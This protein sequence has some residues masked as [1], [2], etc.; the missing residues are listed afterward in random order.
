MTDLA[1]GSL[2]FTYD[3]PNTSSVLSM[4]L[5]E[6]WDHSSGCN[7]CF[8]KITGIGDKS[9]Y[10][11]KYL[12]FSSAIRSISSSKQLP[13]PYPLIHLAVENESAAMEVQSEEEDDLI[14]E[15]SI[16]SCEPH[17]LT[18]GDLNKRLRCE[19]IQ[20]IRNLVFRLKS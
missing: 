16:S 19:I 8:T 20:K 3:S 5:H 9:K 10:K 13:L 2:T 11:I 15:L 14:F 18:Q 17:L 7:F 4:M 6:P 1:N 12:N